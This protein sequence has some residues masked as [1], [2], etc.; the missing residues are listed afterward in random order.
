MGLASL[1]TYDPNSEVSQ[2]NGSSGA[3]ADDL[4][5]KW[6]QAHSRVSSISSFALL[7]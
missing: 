3:T 4:E 1:A 7:S 2:D 5:Q 6:G